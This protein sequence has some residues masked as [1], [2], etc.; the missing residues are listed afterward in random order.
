MTSRDT[1]WK[2]QNFLP[3]LKAFGFIIF[4]FKTEVS[5]IKLNSLI[6]LLYGY[7]T[8]ILLKHRN[9]ITML[10]YIYN[11]LNCRY[12]ALRRLGNYPELQDH[13]KNHIDT[14]LEVLPPDLHSTLKPTFNLLWHSDSHF[15]STYI[16]TMHYVA[17]SYDYLVCS[18]M[19]I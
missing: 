5:L 6:V 1:I 14:L 13:L 18:L 17:V 3:K 11:S 9:Q 10:Y 15:I 19:L 4:A 8:L 7:F 12:D 16:G 2:I